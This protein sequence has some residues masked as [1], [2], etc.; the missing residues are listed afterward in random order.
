MQ[1]YTQRGER[2]GQQRGAERVFEPSVLICNL[3]NQEIDKQGYHEFEFEDRLEC[4]LT[5]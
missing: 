5:Y 1:S 3:S 4:L 2:R